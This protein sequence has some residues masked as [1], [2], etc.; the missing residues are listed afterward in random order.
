MYCLSEK[1]QLW[2]TGKE[3]LPGER[4]AE[5]LHPVHAPVYVTEVLPDEPPNPRIDLQDLEEF[6]PD[7]FWD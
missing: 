2:Q 1:V 4:A 3:L 7:G 6:W 5:P